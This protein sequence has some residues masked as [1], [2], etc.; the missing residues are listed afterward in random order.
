[1]RRVRRRLFNLAAMVSLVLCVVTVALWVRSYIAQDWVVYQ[2]TRP[3][4]RLWRQFTLVPNS[5]QVYLSRPR[6]KF[7][8]DGL[9]GHYRARVGTSDGFS[10]LREPPESQW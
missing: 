8:G 7:G 2:A 6:F 5:G 1:M 3:V 4:D 9:A 10:D